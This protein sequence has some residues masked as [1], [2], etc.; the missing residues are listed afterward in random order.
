MIR[1]RYKIFGLIVFLL[2]LCAG[3]GALLVVFIQEYRRG[4]SLSDA[5]ETFESGQLAEARKKFRAILQDDKNQERACVYLAKISMKEENWQEA[6]TYWRNAASLNPLETKYKRQWKRALAMERDY[7]TLR[8]TFFAS[9]S[10]S[11]PMSDEDSFYFLLTGERSSNI[12]RQYRELLQNR[13]PEFYET[14]FGR[15]ILCQES[16]VH[17]KKKVRILMDL[18]RSKHPVVEFESMILLA[19]EKVADGDTQAGEKILRKAVEKNAFSGLPFLESFY[20]DTLRFDEAKEC[21]ATDFRKYRRPVSAIKLAELYLLSGEAEKIRSLLPK[22]SGNSKAE[23]MT[24]CYLESLMALA[25]NDPQK[26]AVNLRQIR[27]SFGTPVSALVELYDAVSSGDAAAIEADWQIFHQMPSFYDLPERGQQLMTASISKMLERG[28]ERGAARL[29]ALPG[30]NGIVNRRIAD[31]YIANQYRQGKLEES[32]LKQ[33]L[34][35]YPKSPVILSVGAQYFHGKKQYQVSADLV[36]RVMKR[37]PPPEQYRMQAIQAA[38]FAET[39]K[40]K[41]A[42]DLLMLMLTERPEDSRI[43]L[44]ACRFAEKHNRIDDL[45]TICRTLTYARSPLLPFAEGKLLMMQ[46][47]LPRALDRFER[48]DRGHAELLFEAAKILGENDRIAPAVKLYRRILKNKREKRIRPFVL[49]N[50]A[51]LYM[52]ENDLKS[53][54][55]TAEEAWRMQPGHPAMQTCF[56]GVLRR[57]GENRRILEVITPPPSR[58]DQKNPLRKLWIAAAE[59]ELSRQDSAV[60]E[61]S[62]KI[63]STLL[64]LEPESKAGQE[65]QR[66]IALSAGVKK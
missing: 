38:N 36:R 40:L 35:K 29:L 22:L 59:A 27:D 42:A 57:Q 18:A 25:A 24:T 44:A 5:I 9:V 3:L 26:L 45:D 63:C 48:L 16:N 49:V 55:E 34:K 6:V 1:K 41:E 17:S 20:I 64:V 52:A 8:N 7:S 61:A 46:G 56:A 62:K 32:I 14:D 65:F 58:D 28:D 2:L 53:A 10:P 51:E 4:A 60:T 39:G 13:K 33:G 43:L 50:L 19:M 54:G 30:I 66:K 23:M 21:C 47:A 31:F 37:L 12:V 15:F 11:E